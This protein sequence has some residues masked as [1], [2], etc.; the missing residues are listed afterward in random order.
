MRRLLV[1]AIAPILFPV[2]AVA[3]TLEVDASAPTG[4]GKYRR[5]SEAVARAAPGDTILVAPGHYA[6]E[7]V[8][9]VIGPEKHGL[10]IAGSTILERDVRGLPT[11]V[12]QA[13]AAILTG[14]R[15]GHYFDGVMIYVTGEDV[16]I[17]GLVFDGQLVTTGIF[18]DGNMAPGRAIARFTIQDSA[19][20]HCNNQGLFTRGAGGMI[21]GNLF[22]K[23][24]AAQRPLHEYVG[25]GG[26][27]GAVVAGG[28]LLAGNS[29]AT[30]IEVRRNR[31]A[32]NGYAGLFGI[33]DRAT[34]WPPDDP[35]ATHENPAAHVPGALLLTV[36]AN[37][38]SRNHNAGLHFVA[39]GN[40]FYSDPD[41][42]SWLVGTVRNNTFRENFHHG[43][44]IHTPA[45]AG[46]PDPDRCTDAA[47][48]QVRATLVDNAWQGNEAND[49]LFGFT[50]NNYM[51]K[52]EP[53]AC[54]T[55]DN[56][57]TVNGE[58][59]PFDYDAPICDPDLDGCVPL[60]DTLLVNG[61]AVTGRSI[62][63]RR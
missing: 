13:T 40:A 19:F 1:A 22:G 24:T 33:G 43:F 34:A 17:R 36:E 58:V 51:V 37:D 44:T 16:T 9:I 45:G 26:H 12:V 59:P 50:S 8:P 54:Y 27:F 49:A 14:G 10:T 35:R 4:S 42:Q 28:P 7:D 2:A 53:K 31:F 20:R 32:G 63:P 56:Q 6:D 62:T 11:G 25:F 41:E 48:G 60:N 15:T 47:R 29:P 21:E 30:E 46:S 23:V 38:F 57:I 39:H 5:I 3:A 55:H 52:G 61:I 18:V